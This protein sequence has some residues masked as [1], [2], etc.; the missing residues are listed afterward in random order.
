MADFAVRDGECPFAIDTTTLI[1]LVFADFTA[2]YVGFHAGKSIDTATQKAFIVAN[3]AAI[4]YEFAVAGWKGDT[5][6]LIAFVFVSF[7]TNCFE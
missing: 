6:A 4:H 1:C 2:S 7:G 5:A 3:L